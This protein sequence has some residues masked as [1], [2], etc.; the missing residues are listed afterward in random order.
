MLSSELGAKRRGGRSMLRG[1]GGGGGGEGRVTRTRERLL[2]KMS[3]RS[4]S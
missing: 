4:C 1:G 2:R 3:G